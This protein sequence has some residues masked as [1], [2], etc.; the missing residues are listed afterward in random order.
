MAHFSNQVLDLLS[1]LTVEEKAGQ[2]NF[3]VGDLFMTGPTF[4]T[5]ASNKFDDQIRSG[6]ITGLFNI[7]GTEYIHR[8]QKIATE[9][10]RLGIPLLIGADVIHGLKTVFPIPL[11]EAASWNLDLIERTARAAADESTAVGINF[12]FAPMCDVSFDARWGRVAEGA[13]E[14]PYLGGLISAAR[15]KGFQGK[16]LKDEDSLAA[17]V[18]HMAAYGAPEGGRDYNS[19]DMSEY[20]LRQTYLPA[21]KKALDAGAA[22]VMSSF[23][24]LNGVPCTANEYILKQILRDEWGFEGLVVSDWASIAETIPHGTSTDL[25]DAALQCLQAGTDL[26]MMSEAYLQHIPQLIAEGKLAMETLDQAVGQVLTLK[27]KLGLFEDPYRYGSLEREKLVLKS[28]ENLNL[29]RKMAEESMVLLKNEGSI[30][31]LQPNA[32]SIALIGP[33]AH[34]KPDMNGTWAYFAEPNDPVSFL[35]GFEKYQPTSYAQGCELYKSTEEHFE[36]AIEL[37]RNLD[38]I[39]LALGESAVMNGEAASRSDLGLP[40]NQLDLVKALKPLGKPMVALISAGRPLVLTELEPLVD[41][42]MITWSLGTEA[43]NAVAN[44]VFGEAEPVGKLPM[45][46]PR[47]VGQV[48]IH[49]QMKSTG[50]PYSGDYSEPK[51]E[52]IYQSKYRDVENGPLYH[53]GYGLSYTEFQYGEIL[54]SKEE[55]NLGEKLMVS[56]QLRNIGNRKGTETVQLYIR[57]ISASVTRPLK[58]LKSFQKV[59]LEPGE[60]KVVIFEIDEE[61][62]SFYR[63]DMSFGPEPGHFSVYIGGDSDNLKQVNF[64]LLDED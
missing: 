35:E 47:S 7:Y 5:T 36:E 9:E 52:R 40:E 51:S 38:V 8:L 39:V 34:N 60:K 14:D 43:G 18:K 1:K 10:S 4:K 30:L 45:T 33:L 22:T 26:D 59:T 49:Y 41:A 46:F 11:A 21:Y 27:E 25:K 62:L 32:K 53:F 55:I 56:C 3:L 23:N 13:G 24:D 48:P 57:D 37:A 64:T 2:L 58:E 17:C 20:K 12:N 61:M 19:V 54:L 29:A 15:V 44:V 16:D 50:R 42:I 6:E 63:K 28:A 31:P